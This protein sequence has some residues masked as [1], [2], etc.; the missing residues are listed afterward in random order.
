MVT[1]RARH[2]LHPQTVPRGFLRLYILTLLS[3]GPESGYSIIQTI[4]ERT[5]GAWKPGAGTMY[6]LLKGLLKEGLVRAAA[7]KGK[8]GS[9]TYAITAKGKR[10]LE[11]ARRVIA[12]AGKKEPVMGRLFSDLLP[13]NVFVPVMVRR[14]RDG[15]DFLK[16]KLNEIPP[17]EREPYLRELR[18]LLTSQVDWID[19]QLGGEGAVTRRPHARSRSASL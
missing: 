11:E 9:R 3:R 10:E 19:S 15:A 6:P 1:P 16:Q 4:D 5:E 12:G 18:F 17:Q 14:I 13:G 2:W 8:G 7:T